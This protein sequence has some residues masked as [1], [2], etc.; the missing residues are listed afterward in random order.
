MDIGDEAVPGVA[1]GIDDVFIVLP[2]THA[3]LVCSQILPH[4]LDRIEF[5]SIRRQAEERDVI[6]DGQALTGLMPAGPV[7]DQYGMGVGADLPADLGQMDCH[8]LA[9]DPGHDNCGADGAIRT[10]RAEDVGGVVTVVAHRRRSGATRRPQ[11]RQG[12]L[13][14]D[15][16]FILEP[17]LDR[18]SSRLRRQDL[19]YLG[20]EVFLKAACASASFLG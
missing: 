2:D 3:E 4:V 1:A 9:A 12:A 5:W 19:G 17:D 15:P 18:F 8:G 13:L 6:G 14:A 20:S 10:D 11:I 7:T 16:G